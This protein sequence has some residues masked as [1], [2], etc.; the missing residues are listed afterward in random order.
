MSLS[1]MPLTYVFSVF[2]LALIIKFLRSYS[3][4]C[5]DGLFG[6]K[7]NLYTNVLERKFPDRPSALFLIVTKIGF[8]GDVVCIYKC[9]NF[10]VHSR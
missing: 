1:A 2:I 5:Y 4:V 6:W 3:F 10:N 9:K 7:E 8:S